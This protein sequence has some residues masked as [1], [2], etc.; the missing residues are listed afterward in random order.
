M[1]FKTGFDG[2]DGNLREPSAST[3][4]TLA[5]I[6]EIATMNL[7]QH[8]AGYVLGQ[9]LPSRKEEIVRAWT[10]RDIY[11]GT[12]TTSRLEGAHISLKR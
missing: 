3:T 12:I 11:R 6:Q 5:Q 10:D 2:D 4:P 9:C 1:T 8:T 7:K